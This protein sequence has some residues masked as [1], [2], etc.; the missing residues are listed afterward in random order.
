MLPDDAAPFNVGA[1]AAP[2]P[3]INNLDELWM[4]LDLWKDWE[5]YYR[6]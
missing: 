2:L 1:L 5:N 3:F 6:R 4:F